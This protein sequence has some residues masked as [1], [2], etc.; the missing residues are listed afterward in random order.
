MMG[1]R[2]EALGLGMDKRAL[3]LVC[4]LGCWAVRNLGKLGGIDARRD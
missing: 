1:S 4:R 3:G 2:G